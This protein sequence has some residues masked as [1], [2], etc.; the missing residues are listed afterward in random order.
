V[1]AVAHGIRERGEVPLLHAAG[2]NTRAIAVYERLGF[3]LRR[4]PAFELL[5]APS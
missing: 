4:R 1:L 2:T 3:R 5:R